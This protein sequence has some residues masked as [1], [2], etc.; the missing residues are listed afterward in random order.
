MQ[1]SNEEWSEIYNHVKKR[2]LLFSASVFSTKSIAVLKK[3]GVDIWKI[4]SGES[5]DLGLIK[6]V[7]NVSSKPLFISTGM[8]T[9]KEVDNIYNF[10]KKKNDF[11]LMHCISQ[12]PCEEK[13]R[14]EHT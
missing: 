3:I 1:F 10:M 9:Q 5:L 7:T 2:K 4:P 12:Y 14:H 6:E 11:M 8:N 13:N